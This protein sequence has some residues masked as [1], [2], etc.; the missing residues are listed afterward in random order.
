[1]D[2]A[3]MRARP[4]PAPAVEVVDRDRRRLAGAMTSD[5]TPSAPG[6]TGSSD[7]GAGQTGRTARRGTGR[8]L[9]R[10]RL[11]VLAAA[12]VLVV[13]VGALMA[14]GS[15][16]TATRLATTPSSQADHVP[17]TPAPYAG[18]DPKDLAAT[19]A[20]P[21]YLPAGAEHDVGK[22]TLRGGWA[23][24]WTLPGEANS[25]IMPATPAEAEPGVWYHPATGISLTQ[26]PQ[27][28]SSF[29]GADERIVHITTID[30]GGVA[31]T[32]VVPISGYGDYRIAWVRSGVAYD[33]QSQR[34]KVSADGAMSGV[35]IDE[36]IRVAQSIG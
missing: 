10:V 26:L 11:G 28:I 16:E 27:T 33:L 34:L 19:H 25:R 22:A 3:M 5:L 31:A 18:V 32:V 17:P 23:D 6:A 21:K 13:G 14:R 35:P 4:D 8:I 36:L 15:G 24:N 30:L 29:P 9:R 1:M 20:T 7:L 2:E 12:V